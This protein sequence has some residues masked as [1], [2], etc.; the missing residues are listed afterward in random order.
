MSTAD[1]CNK[2]FKEKNVVARDS[3]FCWKSPPNGIINMTEFLKRTKDYTHVMKENG[4]L[5]DLLELQKYGQ[6]LWSTSIRAKFVAPQRTPLTNLLCP[7]CDTPKNYKKQGIINVGRTIIHASLFWGYFQSG[8]YLIR[9]RTLYQYL[10]YLSRSCRLPG[11]I[12]LDTQFSL[13]RPEHSK[14]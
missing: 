8:L 9:Q 14:S 13:W 12:S 7:W 3:L 11:S 1:S 5:V 2:K 10:R 4:L 6:F